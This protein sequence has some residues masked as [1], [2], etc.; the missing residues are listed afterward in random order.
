MLVPRLCLGTFSEVALPPTNWTGGRAA[1]NTFPGRAWERASER[2]CLSLT[3]M[4]F[5]PTLFLGL[6]RSCIPCMKFTSPKLYIRPNHEYDKLVYCQHEHF[7]NSD[8]SLLFSRIIHHFYFLQSVYYSP[9]SR[10]FYCN[11]LIC[12]NIFCK[13]KRS[14]LKWWMF[15]SFWNDAFW[16]GYDR[17]DPALFRDDR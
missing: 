9:L 4:G 12:S 10:S 1:K 5:S 2:V 7:L 11:K 14:L 6:P 15:K 16:T 3:A 8:G 13:L 17:S